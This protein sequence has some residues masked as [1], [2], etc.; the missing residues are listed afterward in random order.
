MKNVKFVALLGLA[1]FS[2][3]ML[4]WA[5]SSSVP[6]PYLARLESG[7]RGL[8]R[9][10]LEGGMARALERYHLNASEAAGVNLPAAARAAPLAHPEAERFFYVNARGEITI[11]GLSDENVPPDYSQKCLLFVDA[12]LS[13]FKMRMLLEAL[14]DAKIHH[15]YLASQTT[16]GHLNYT[17]F[18][19]MK[20]VGIELLYPYRVVMLAD[21][22][23]YL[24]CEEEDGS[25]QEG[26][27]S[28]RFVR[29]TDLSAFKKTAQRVRENSIAT[30]PFIRFLALDNVTC[31]AF[32]HMLAMCEPGGLQAI[33]KVRTQD[34]A[35]IIAEVAE[36]HAPPEKKEEQE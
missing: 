27:D 25:L 24:C 28:S 29:I 30:K 33:I 1:A 9:Q 16:Q 4:L 8:V 5:A 21:G 34:R 18:E 7:E 3:A 32:Y 26:P 11:K 10:M 36:H 20:P 12:G 17:H 14:V 15:V 23:V 22:I 2:F 13:W 6:V 35:D 19:V 31:G